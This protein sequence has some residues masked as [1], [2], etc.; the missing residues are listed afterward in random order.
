[1]KYGILRA[2][3]QAN[4]GDFTILMW[5][6]KTGKGSLDEAGS[7]L[8]HMGFFESVAGPVLPSVSIY[9]SHNGRN[10]DSHYA[11]IYSSCNSEPYKYISSYG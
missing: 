10:D 3:V 11:R 6:K 2:D 5:V 1:M 4:G 7:F 9:A 8:P